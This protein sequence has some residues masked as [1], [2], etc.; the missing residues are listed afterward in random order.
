MS[1]FIYKFEAV[2][3]VKE[4]LEKKVQKE[5][6]LIEAQIDKC[7]KDFEQ[8]VDE[9]TKNKS[10]AKRRTKISEI[11]FNK[12]YELYMEKRKNMVLQKINE[13]N[14]QKEKKMNE[15]VQKS[16]EHKIFD[17]LEEKHKEI[18]MQ[19]Q[20]KAELVNTDE[21]AIQRYVREPN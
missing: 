5:L 4:K 14:K 20:N 2:K 9:E 8:L 6:A 11:N 17:S 19:E 21:M 10:A 13:L 3:N 12:G 18:F 7:Q 16:K 15:L 1:K